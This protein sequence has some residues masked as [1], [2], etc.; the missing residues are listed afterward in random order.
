MPR[1]IRASKNAVAS[2]ANP[3]AALYPA[4]KPTV[5]P[6]RLTHLQTTAL[7]SYQRTSVVSHSAL[8]ARKIPLRSSTNYAAITTSIGTPNSTGQRCA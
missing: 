4:P 7:C 5:Q 1:P 2:S 3:S 8:G 6:D